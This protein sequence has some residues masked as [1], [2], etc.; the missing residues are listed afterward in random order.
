MIHSGLRRVAPL[1]PLLYFSVI[2]SPADSSGALWSQPQTTLTAGAVI[3]REI[4]GDEQH[5]Y[6]LPLAAGQFARIVV[7]QPGV[8]AVLTLL[9]PDGQPLVEVNNYAQYEPEHLS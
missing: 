6:L 2:C 4:G 8:D 5:L 7:E 3:K 9:K 1:A